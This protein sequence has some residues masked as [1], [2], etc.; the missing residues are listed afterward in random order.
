[1]ARSR[2]NTVL[3]FFKKD[4]HL[5]QYLCFLLVYMELINRRGPNERA[6]KCCTWNNWNSWNYQKTET[7][8]DDQ[9]ARTA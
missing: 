4:L 1:M 2:T 8:W 3:L 7:I 5:E 6:V 9:K